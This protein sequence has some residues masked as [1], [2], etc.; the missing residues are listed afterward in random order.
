MNK[1]R[2]VRK[3]IPRIEKKSRNHLAIISDIKSALIAC[4]QNN[5]VQEIDDKLLIGGTPL[6]KLVLVAI[7]IEIYQKH[8]KAITASVDKLMTEYLGYCLAN[9]YYPLN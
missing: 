4:N 1:L 8:N 7:W 2:N 6:E 5:E 9:K 3:R